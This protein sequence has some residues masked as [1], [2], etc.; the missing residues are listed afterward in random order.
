M[1]RS[2][3]VRNNIITILGATALLLA[4]AQATSANVSEEVAWGLDGRMVLRENDLKAREDIKE[5][6]M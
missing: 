4:L 2:P 5:I 1:R 6:I 3:R